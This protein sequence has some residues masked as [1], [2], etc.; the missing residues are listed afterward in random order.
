VFRLFFF[1]DGGW[2]ADET[3]LGRD[4]DEADFYD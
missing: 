4:A 2:N 1:G 3:D